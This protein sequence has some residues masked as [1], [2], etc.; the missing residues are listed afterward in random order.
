[1]KIMHLFSSKVF[2]GLERHLEE[3]TFEQSKNHEVVVLGPKN[4][5]ENFRCEYKALNTNQ[6]RHSPILF[7]QI[8]AMINSVGPDVLHTHANKMTS[9]INKLSTPVPHISTIHGTKIRFYIRSEQ[10]IA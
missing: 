4:L 10:K 3:L 7:N 8:K 2:A 5:K 1:M 6:W 9:L